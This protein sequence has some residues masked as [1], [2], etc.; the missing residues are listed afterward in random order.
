M[1][2][3]TD[4]HEAFLLK[5]LGSALHGLPLPTWDDVDPSSVL[6]LAHRHKVTPL[7]YDAFASLPQENPARSGA[8]DEARVNAHQFWRLLLLTHFCTQTLAEQGIPSVILK[9]AG[10]A[11][12]WPVPE[13]RKSGDIDL[14]PV[15]E[16]DFFKAQAC[17]ES[18]GFVP[19]EFQPA[20]HQVVMH[21]ADRMEIELHRA[22]VEDFD[23]ERVNARFREER[24][25]LAPHV[26]EREVLGVSI[27]VLDQA[28]Q[29]FHLLSHMAQDLLR[30][31]FGLRLLCDW[32][33]L[34][35]QEDALAF[36]PA[37]LDLVRSAGL[38]GLSQNVTWLC[39]NR[40]ELSSPASNLLS[41]GA[42][43]NAANALLREVLDAGDF[44]NSSVN[45]MVIPRSAAPSDLLRE[46]HH[47][48]KLNFPKASR[49]FLAWPVL[50]TATL[51]RFLH[52]NRT[53]RHTSARAVL[54]T[55][56]QRS[57][58]HKQL[59]IFENLNSGE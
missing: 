15:H 39:Q 51:V 30:N 38:E 29:A 55:A 58:L 35:E 34:W 48:T 27:P 52:N 3:P 10:A 32:V 28:H 49:V 7:L 12:N 47:Q 11:A 46:F 37:Y 22:L 33:T 40:L 13:Q 53:L 41:Q 31:G 36:V 42:S 18:L 9:G 26:I 23:D 6:D 16:E 43:E 14:L 24:A 20:N 59:R 19:D 44:G 2:E 56:T 17:L 45:R 4:A 54:Q 21:N 25:T 57:Q 5:A 8:L 50:W 1:P